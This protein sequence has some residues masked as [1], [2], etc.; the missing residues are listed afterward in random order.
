MTW[1]GG[2]EAAMAT[3]PPSAA[4]FRLVQGLT[5]RP[6]EPYCKIRPA[7]AGEGRGDADGVATGKAMRISFD[8]DNTLICYQPEVPQEPRLPG[9]LRWLAINEPL[10]RGTVD[11]IRQLR[12]RGWEVWIYTTSHRRESAVRRWLRLH[13]ARIDGFVNQ[14]VHESHL[15]RSPEDRP[16]SKNPAV[17]GI[18][19]H[20]D[21]SEGVKIEGERYG[22]QVVVVAPEDVEWADKVLRAVGELE[23]RGVEP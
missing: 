18:D 17:F 7:R 10:R 3:T 5:G 14:D 13:G 23:R 1:G 6:R 21:D 4:Q 2:I 16:P 12:S 15:R 8:L 11:L 19:L 20:V 22:F 9:Y